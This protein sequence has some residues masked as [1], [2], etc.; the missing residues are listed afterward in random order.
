L[1]AYEN[2]AMTGV[3]RTFTV[4]ATAHD[5]VNIVAVELWYN[6]DGGG[7]TTSLLLNDTDGSNG[8]SWLFSTL[9]TGDGQYD[10]YTRAIDAS[11]NYEDAPVIT[12]NGTF[13]D[14]TI[15]IGAATGPASSST[16]TFDVTYSVT[17]ST[18][19]GIALITLYYTTNGGLT[20]YLCG[21]DSDVASPIQVTVGSAGSYGWIICAVDNAGNAESFP[22]VPI[23][24]TT[25]SVN[26]DSGNDFATATDITGQLFWTETVDDA[27][28]TDDYFKIWLD[29]GDSL[30][31]GMVG[32][33]L[34]DFDLYL[35]D[36]SQIQ[37]DYSENLGSIESVSCA[38]VTIA[39]Y[40][41]L[42]VYAYSGSG[43]YTLTI[44]QT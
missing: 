32:P 6:H 34:D 26:I 15:P 41:Y 25:T 37:I 28:D 12:D 13:V 31:I 36:P 9:L 11:G 2:D 10:F 40:Y 5:N 44:I 16:A 27:T 42:D 8:W 17:D 24:E 39:G 20:W 33:L 18:G 22:I 1:P 30:T 23:P 19:D 43:S 35:Y 21:D 38:S 14:T 29:V 3:L 4:T 7:W